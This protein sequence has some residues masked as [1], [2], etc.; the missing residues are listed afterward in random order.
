[1]RPEDFDLGGLD[2]S[3]ATMR[4]LFAIKPDEWKKELESQTKFFESVGE[5]MPGELIAQHDN[6]AERF[7]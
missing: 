6:V 1:P 5:D 7:G 3:R 4:E 2:I